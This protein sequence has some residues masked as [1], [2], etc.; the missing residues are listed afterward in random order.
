MQFDPDEDGRLRL[1]K[2][3]G[4]RTL[5]FSHLTAGNRFVRGGSS[6]TKATAF[7]YSDF[8]FLALPSGEV[9]SE[10]H[11]GEIIAPLSAAL[12]HETIH[13]FHRLTRSTPDPSLPRQDRANGF[14]EE[15][16][17]TRSREHRLIRQVFCHDLDSRR[18]SSGALLNAGL[19]SSP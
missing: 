3:K 15:E 10:V 14:I 18:R 4:R 9:F 2:F 12:A 13:A 6:R 7:P 19:H 17:A 16:I 11:Q 1:G 8:I 5:V